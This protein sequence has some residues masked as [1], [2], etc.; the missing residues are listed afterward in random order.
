VKQDLAANE[1]VP[2]T[3]SRRI[4]QKTNKIVNTHNSI[5]RIVIPGKGIESTK[6]LPAFAELNGRVSIE[7]TN[8]RTHHRD[9]K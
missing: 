6:L 9:S 3:F 4:R 7:A 1:W 5:I 2:M 8:I